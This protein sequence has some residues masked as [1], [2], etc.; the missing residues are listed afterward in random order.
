MNSTPSDGK[1][2]KSNCTLHKCPGIL[3]FAAVCP[4]LLTGG[5]T[6]E[7]LAP[8]EVNAESLKAD[9]SLF[10]ILL[11]VLQCSLNSVGTYYF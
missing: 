6:R 7:L 10:R 2:K 8:L 1:V 9:F 3:P 4:G 5:S 11:H